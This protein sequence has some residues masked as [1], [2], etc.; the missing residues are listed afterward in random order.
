M[1]HY[2]RLAGV[3]ERGAT[4]CLRMLSSDDEAM[5]EVVNLFEFKARPSEKGP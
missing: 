3:D 4:E 1:Q 2:I 5:A